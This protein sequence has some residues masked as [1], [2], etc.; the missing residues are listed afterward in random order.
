MHSESENCDAKSSGAMYLGNLCPGEIEEH[1]IQGPKVE[2]S[3]PDVPLSV[4]ESEEGRRSPSKQIVGI[5]M[6]LYTTVLGYGSES[7]LIT[8]IGSPINCKALTCID[9]LKD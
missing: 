5:S 9:I 4:Q 3:T 7:I 8:G 6:T 2:P 1:D